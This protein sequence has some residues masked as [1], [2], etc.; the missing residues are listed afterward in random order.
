[1][2]LHAEHMTYSKVSNLL[3]LGISGPRHNHGMWC[4]VQCLCHHC[5]QAPMHLDL[6]TSQAH[7]VYD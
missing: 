2:H 3:A 1:M 4:A 5:M 6:P 7:R